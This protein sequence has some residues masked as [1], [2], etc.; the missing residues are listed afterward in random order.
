MAN[1]ANA[2]KKLTPNE[3]AL[4]EG[5]DIVKSHKLFGRIGGRTEFAKKGQFAKGTAAVV[6]SNGNVTLNPYESRTPREWA[7]IIAHCQ[8]HLCFGHFNPEKMPGYYQEQKD[9]KQKWIEHCDRRLWNMACDI[10]VDKFL[11]EI[12]FGTSDISLDRS[13]IA[14]DERKI[15]DILLQRGISPD[16][17]LYGTSCGGMPDMIWSERHYW[18]N[19][20]DYYERKFVYALADSVQDVIDEA[21]GKTGS[22]KKTIQIQ[23]AEW[24]VNHYPLLG[25]LASAFKII[26]VGYG[27]QSVINRN[28][29]VAAIDIEKREI[30]VNTT[31]KLSFEEWKFV[32]AHE[33][34]HA[35][36]MH[37]ERCEGREPFLWNAACDFVINGWLKDMQVGVMPSIGA[38]YDEGYKDYSA[39]EIYDILVE[40]IRQNDDLATFAGSGE[41]DILGGGYKPNSED[42][43][44]LDD[45]C[46][47]A[48][49]AGLEYHEEKNR[50]YIPAGLIEE[51]RA[52]SEPPI[53]WDVQLAKWFEDNF[54]PIEK[55]RTYARPSRRQSSTPDI[56]RPR[57]VVA[58]VPEY[59]RTYGVVIDTS[60]SMSPKEIGIALGAVVSYS[61]EKEV[62]LVRVVF[63]DA[64]AY[65][66]GWLRPDDM[67]GVVEV[68]GRGGTELQPAV[69]LLENSKDF[70]KDG[71]I[72]IIT[73]GF[74][75]STLTIHHEHAFLIPRGYRLPF[76]AKGKVFYFNE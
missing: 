15:Y 58:D 7:N 17:N 48:L 44:S 61:V 49:R 71:P 35:G 1:K 23:A 22:D 53:P 9:G 28:I 36:L 38:L 45:F 34:L 69:D 54:Q 16:T 43:V 27:S 30:Y 55:K 33:Y 4:Y 39:E 42:V 64:D 8:L 67:A 31:T 66:A 62:P 37:H 19:D 10:Y 6:D 70:P 12:K 32:L 21:G 59:S 26:E 20:I 24:F 47:N 18:S 52:L 60:G 50:G 3:Q 74:I 29:S 46:R 51:I 41:G 57:Y 2:G 11:E 40:N 5:I 75:E 13:L 65:D 68:K 76:K 63:C 25:A 56:P 73:D 14:S 72:L